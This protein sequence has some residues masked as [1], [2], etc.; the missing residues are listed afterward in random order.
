MKASIRCPYEDYCTLYT[1]EEDMRLLGEVQLEI[2]EELKNRYDRALNEF[3]EV[4]SLLRDAY[5]KAGGKL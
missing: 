2:T 1:D 3:F 4:Q 5:Y